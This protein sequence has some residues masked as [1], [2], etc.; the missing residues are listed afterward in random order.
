MEIW[1]LALMLLAGAGAGFINVFAGGGSTITIPLLQIFGLPPIVANGTN[2][3]STMVGNLSTT[4]NFRLKKKISIRAH[5]PHL[6]PLSLGSWIGSTLVDFTPPEIYNIFQTA[7]ILMVLVLVLWRPGQKLQKQKAAT[8]EDQNTHRAFDWGAF[9]RLAV[10]YLFIGLY[11]GYI[12]IGM[13]FLFM[14][15][16][17]LFTDKDQAEINA[18]KLFMGGAAALVSLLRFGLSGNIQ[19]IP[20]ILVAGGYI[21]GGW[22]ASQLHFKGGEKIMKPILVVAVVSILAK[23]FG[24]W[25]WVIALFLP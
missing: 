20:G 14:I 18:S 24:F 5:L 15:L 7:V 4:L 6:I 22:V 25:D 21:G 11:A 16:L 12:L 10:I 23:L 13:G 1:Q 3:I 2:R 17:A 9:F 8:V 19:W